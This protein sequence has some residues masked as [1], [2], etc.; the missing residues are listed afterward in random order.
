MVFAL[1]LGRLLVVAIFPV[2]AYFKIMGWPG[3]V[4]AVGKLGLPYPEYIAMAGIALEIVAPFLILIGWQTRLAALGLIVFTVVATYIGHPA[5]AVP[6]AEFFGQLTHVLKNIALCGALL[7][8]MGTG[9]GAYSV[10]G[11]KAG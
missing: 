2:I 9:P 4:Q 7:M 8:L 5:W 6:P 10:T 3:I 11:R 1:L